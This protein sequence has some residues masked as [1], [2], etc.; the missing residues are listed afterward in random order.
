MDKG[1]L[2]K[3]LLYI[4][5]NEWSKQSY[6]QGFDFEIPFKKALNMFKWMEIV[7]LIY[8]GGVGTNSK[9]PTDWTVTNHS[10]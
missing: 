4:R 6:L 5:L 7:E 9:T 1:E 10:S 8:E 2:N 3:I